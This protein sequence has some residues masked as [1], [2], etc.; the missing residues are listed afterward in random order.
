MFISLFTN[1]LL[2]LSFDYLI[3]LKLVLEFNLF[4]KKKNMNKFGSYSHHFMILLNF[5]DEQIVLN[6]NKL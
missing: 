3:E 6:L 1:K 4:A 2:Y 5:F